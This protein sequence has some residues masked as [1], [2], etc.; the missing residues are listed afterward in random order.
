MV[1]K[2]LTLGPFESNCYIVFRKDDQDRRALV[3]DPGDGVP[4]ILSFIEKHRLKVVAYPITHGHIDHVFGLARVHAKHP[5]PIALHPKDS[6][7]A[8]TDINAM[9]PFYDAPEAPA[10]IAREFKEGQVWED[11]GLKYKIMET[12][13]HS[14]GGVCLYFFELGI[15]FSGDTLFRGSIGRIDLPGGDAE[16]YMK[17][18][19]RLLTLPDETI[20]YPGHGPSTTI[21][22]ER[23]TNPF[24][25]V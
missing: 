22:I 5:A 21:G 24:L 15:L 16:T 20:V 19:P 3:I 12:P 13:G 6:K 17:T 23:K 9:P 4:E 25:Q 11:A 1:V 10:E 8:F 7:W 2:T 18:L 14:P